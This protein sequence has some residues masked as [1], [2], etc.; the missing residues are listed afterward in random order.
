MAHERY[1]SDYEEAKVVHFKEFDGVL[2]GHLMVKSAQSL[3]RTKSEIEMILQ[4]YPPFYLE[5]LCLP[6]ATQVPNPLPS[7]RDTKRGGWIVGIGLDI[8]N[9]ECYVPWTHNMGQVHECP[10]DFKDRGGWLGPAPW[11]HTDLVYS[12]KRF[13]QALANIRNCFPTDETI[14]CAFRL[15][16]DMTTGNFDFGCSAPMENVLPDYP[17][18]ARVVNMLLPLEQSKIAINAFNHWMPLTDEERALFRAYTPQILGAAFRGLFKVFMYGHYSLGRSGPCKLPPL[19]ELQDH[20]YIYL[21][22]CEPTL[23]DQII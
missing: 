15:F 21:T 18:I 1:A 11:K 4:G 12:V 7:F 2:T 22:S 5:S 23:N 6:D 13:G 17:E 10:A 20:K 9:P 3:R 14:A 8:R 19:P 16:S